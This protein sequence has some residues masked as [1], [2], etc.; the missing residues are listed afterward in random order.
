[1]FAGPGTI[2][3]VR[4]RHGRHRSEDAGH[5]SHVFVIPFGRHVPGIVELVIPGTYK[6]L[7]IVVSVLAAVD[8][9]RAGIDIIFAVVERV[10]DTGGQR[11]LCASRPHC[12]VVPAVHAKTSPLYA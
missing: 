8:A 1:M 12:N 6:E 3:P 4:I 2:R 5:I 10:A 9:A 11:R 7:H